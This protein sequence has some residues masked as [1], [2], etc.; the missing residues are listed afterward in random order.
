MAN[1]DRKFF[2]YLSTVHW[3]N[4]FPQINRFLSKLVQKIVKY[5]DG[6]IC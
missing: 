5:N 4:Y 6:F 2:F 3:Q 1:K